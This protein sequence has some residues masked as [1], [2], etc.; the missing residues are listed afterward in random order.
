MK[1][2]DFNLSPEAGAL[3]CAARAIR[4]SRTRG[5][6]LL[7]RLLIMAWGVC[8]LLSGRAFA[9]DPT[10]DLWQYN[11]RTWTRQTGL[12]VN[13]I[14]AIAQTGDGYLWFGTSVGLVRFDGMEF[15][16][17]DLS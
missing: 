15:T 9:L 1:T 14:N 5:V 6:P 10:K 2:P 7:Q 11:T 8:L 4:P 17:L 13:G 16:L 12:P 3:G